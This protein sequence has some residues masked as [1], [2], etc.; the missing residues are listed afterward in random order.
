MSVTETAVVK[1]IR[2]DYKYG[3][4]EEEN[5]SFKSKRGLSREIVEEISA[6][7]SEP[8]WM[9]KARLKAL[10][11]FYARPLPDWGGNVAEI[12]FD[13]IYYYIKPIESQVSSWEDLPPE[14]KNTW[15]KLG[16]PGG[17]AEVPGWCWCPV[18]VGG[19]LPQPQAEPR[20]P[21]CHLP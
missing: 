19:D 20:R 21:G 13:N 18:R 6:H 4:H 11:Y 3:F 14:I 12:D 7:K 9:L 1:D 15:D 8:A 16:H 5:Y 10:D 2:S 17:G